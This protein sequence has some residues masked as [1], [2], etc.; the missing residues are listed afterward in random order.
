MCIRS[1]TSNRLRSCAVV[2]DILRGFV[3]IVPFNLGLEAPGLHIEFHRLL[4]SR[5]ASRTADHRRRVRSISSFRANRPIAAALR[6]TTRCSWSRMTPS[7]RRKSSSSTSY[8]AADVHP[9]QYRRP[10]TAF[11]AS[12]GRRKCRTV[13]GFDHVLDR[14]P[15]GARRR[16]CRVA[17]LAPSMDTD[18][19]P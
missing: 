12:S 9:P 15:K 5:S 18:T 2:M 6:M 13:V 1:A 8:K 4:I 17:T 19:A 14:F 16:R 7:C 11:K 10:R 3:P